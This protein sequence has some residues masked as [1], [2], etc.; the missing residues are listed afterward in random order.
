MISLMLGRIGT[1]GEE[2]LNLTLRLPRYCFYETMSS[3]YNCHVTTTKKSDHKLQQLGKNQRMLT[4]LCFILAQRS[5]FPE[6]PVIF[7]AAQTN[8][9]LT[10]S[11]QPS[12][13]GTSACLNANL[14]G[15]PGSKVNC[16]GTKRVPW[17]RRN[18]IAGTGRSERVF[19]RDFF[20]GPSIVGPPS[21]ESLPY[22]S[23]TS[24]V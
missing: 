16:P 9:N 5:T 4:S 3:P 12:R 22:H 8:Q 1:T 20:Q 19:F 23:H 15:D 21:K 24:R 13:L 14:L 7:F 2:K 17:R 6:H 10:L 18:Y 11:P